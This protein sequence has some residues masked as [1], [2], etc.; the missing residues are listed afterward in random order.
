MNSLFLR[1]YPSG[2]GTGHYLLNIVQLS[3]FC[4]PGRCLGIQRETKEKSGKN[5]DVPMKASVL[6]SSRSNE[7][8]DSAASRN[9]G[10]CV[11]IV[12]PFVL[13]Y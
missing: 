9:L 4:D 11:S 10:R 2:R 6:V 7:T 13:M 12:V 3:C 8:H 1:V 5:W